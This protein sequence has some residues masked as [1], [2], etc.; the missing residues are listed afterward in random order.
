MHQE[1]YDQTFP[2]TVI[3]KKE[4]ED[5]RAVTQDQ[6]AA[7]RNLGQGAHPVPDNFVFGKRNEFSG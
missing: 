1:R 4:V 7:T 2:K 3:V 6:L 5:M